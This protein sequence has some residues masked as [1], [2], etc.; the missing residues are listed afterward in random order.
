MTFFTFKILDAAPQISRHLYQCRFD[1]R[2]TL[3][4][5][6]H[7]V[8]HLGFDMVQSRCGVC[9]ALPQSFVCI[10]QDTHPRTQI[11][12]IDSSLPLMGKP[13]TGEVFRNTAGVVTSLYWRVQQ[14]VEVTVTVV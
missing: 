7:G 14:Q 11:A 8:I 3:T 5:C 13:E 1:L 6:D 9:K 10:L 2:C 12:D 4:Q